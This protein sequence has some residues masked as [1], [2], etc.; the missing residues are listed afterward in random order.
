MAFP[1]FGSFIICVFVVFSWIICYSCL[2]ICFVLFDFILFCLIMFWLENLCDL[3]YW[4]IRFDVLNVAL[5]CW[6]ARNAEQLLFWWICLDSKILGTPNRLLETSTKIMEWISE[7][8]N[9]KKAWANFAMRCG[10]HAGIPL[11][12]LPFPMP[13]SIG[14]ITSF[15]HP[16]KKKKPHFLEITPNLLASSS[17][18]QGSPP[19]AGFQH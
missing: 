2:E 19:C 15:F 10:V 4:W 12:T 13:T 11:G 7:H 6:N 8:K 3:I 16:K 18:G 9:G 1:W 14:K 5:V 17:Q